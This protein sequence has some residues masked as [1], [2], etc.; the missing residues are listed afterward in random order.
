MTGHV[1]FGVAVALLLTWLILIE[2]LTIP[3]RKVLQLEAAYRRF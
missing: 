3:K 2:A 1:L